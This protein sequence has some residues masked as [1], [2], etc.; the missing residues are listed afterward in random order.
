MNFTRSYNL[1]QAPIFGSG[2][3]LNFPDAVGPVGYVAASEGTIDVPSGSATGVAF[4][5]PFGTIAGA[6]AAFIQNAGPS[7]TINVGLNGATGSFVELPPGGS[8]DVA[9]P[10][11]A[12]GNPLRTI[13][14]AVGAVQPGLG[15]VKYILLGE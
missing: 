1:N 10:V 9:L 15:Q 4:Q 14:V 5:V 6:K 12:T 11:A 3:Q 2:P 13:A 8:I 7:G